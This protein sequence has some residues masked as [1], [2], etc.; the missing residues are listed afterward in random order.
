[1]GSQR[2]RESGLFEVTK[3]SGAS[4]AGSSEQRRV[5]Q[6]GVGGVIWDVFFLMF[7]VELTTIITLLMRFG[8]WPLGNLALQAQAPSSAS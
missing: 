4:S 5:R 6:A 8:Y 1:M 7:V 3:Y 2:H